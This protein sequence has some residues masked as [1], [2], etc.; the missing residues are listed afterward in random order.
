LFAKQREHGNESLA[1]TSQRVNALSHRDTLRDAGQHCVVAAC[2]A[3]IALHDAALRQFHS[4]SVK[5]A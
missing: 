4:R 2:V 5:R 1:S 3:A